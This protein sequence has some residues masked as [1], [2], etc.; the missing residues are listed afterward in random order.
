M[1]YIKLTQGKR[2]MVDDADYAWLNQWKW[3][4]AKIR[5]TYYVLRG[6]PH[7]RMHRVIMGLTRYDGKEIDHRNGDALDNRRANLRICTHAENMHN[8]KPQAGKASRHKGVYYSY[9]KYVAGIKL[10]RKRIHIGCFANEDDAGR[11][12]DKKARELFGEF[13]R[14]NFP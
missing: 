12:Y 10:N 2:T 14:L 3:C 6:S 9:G 13:A 11:A 8:Q 1:K 7:V 4:T 5:G